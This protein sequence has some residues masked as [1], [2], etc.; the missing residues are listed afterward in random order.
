MTLKI[1]H[2]LVIVLNDWTMNKILNVQK[3]K[4]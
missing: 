2:F 1:T 3:K 4:T